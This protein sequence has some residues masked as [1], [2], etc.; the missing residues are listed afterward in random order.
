MSI[1]YHYTAF[2]PHQ[3]CTI[4]SVCRNRLKD[5]YIHV[6]FCVHLQHRSETGPDVCDP[7]PASAGGGCN[8][9][10]LLYV[11]GQFGSV[12]ESLCAFVHC[13]HVGLQVHSATDSCEN[14]SR[15][16]TLLMWS[17]MKEMTGE[18]LRGKIWKLNTK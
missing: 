2:R 17:S 11:P 14:T 12:C 3:S 4:T 15:H 8:L 10:S 5:C 7:T 1:R 6:L 18:A 16:E 13:L 9:R